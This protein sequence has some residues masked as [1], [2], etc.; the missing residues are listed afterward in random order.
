MLY[1]LLI[2]IS[3]MSVIN[4]RDAG[5]FGKI[6]IIFCWPAALFLIVLAYIGNR[7]ND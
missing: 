2:G 6:F 1:Y 4:T 7:K 5:A 3:L